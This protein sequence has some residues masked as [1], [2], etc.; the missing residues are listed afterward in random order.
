MKGIV[1]AGPAIP[2][3]DTPW[4]LFKTNLIF[5]YG[6]LDLMAAIFFGSI[7]LSIIKSKMSSTASNN[8]KRL[9]FVGF[10]A[11]IIGIGLLGLVYIGQSF[12]GAHFGAGLEGLNDGQAFRSIVFTVIGSYGAAIVGSAALLACFS[13]AIAL[14]AVTAEYLQKDILG[15]KIGYVPALVIMLLASAPLAIAGL[16]TVLQLAGG[17]ITFVG[18]PALIMLTFCNI[19]YKLFNFK[20]VKIPVIS[21]FVIALVIYFV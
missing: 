4:N 17:P 14:G 15:N 13:T 9:A 12:L 3:T 1:T 5:G 11:G 6:T 8:L 10:I 21:T 2:A 16:D 18:Y 19:G 20:P 7:V